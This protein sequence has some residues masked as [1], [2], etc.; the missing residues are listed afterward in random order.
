[1]IERLPCRGLVSCDEPRARRA[2][3]NLVGLVCPRSWDENGSE[4]ANLSMRRIIVKVTATAERAGLCDH[5]VA[6]ADGTC[7]HVT[8][9]RQFH[10]A[11]VWLARRSVMVEEA[12]SCIHTVEQG[13]PVVVCMRL[14]VRRHSTGSPPFCQSDS[15]QVDGVLASSVK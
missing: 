4:R 9:G 6:V 3:F 7:Q 11:T 8:G 14:G 1:V 15:V 13:V 10:G 5:K 12:R 2:E